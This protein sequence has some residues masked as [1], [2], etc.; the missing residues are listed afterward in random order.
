[1]AFFGHHEVLA[2]P[3]TPVH[4]GIEDDLNG[5]GIGTDFS[6][7]NAGSEEIGSNAELGGS[8]AESSTYDLYGLPINDTTED[9]IVGTNTVNLTGMS[10]SPMTPVGTNGA[11]VNGSG[12]AGQQIQTRNR[13]ESWI[14]QIYESVAHGITRQGTSVTTAS[15]APATQ[16][17]ISS[18][19]VT[20]VQSSAAGI[21]FHGNLV[22][23]AILGI[24]IGLVVFGDF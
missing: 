23:F 5:G 9:S 2:A 17:V 6:D 11:N 1:M 4:Y 19:P 24:V 8:E 16:G 3:A 10:E 15:Q 18:A 13:A 21:S 20:L 22:L 7:P 12:S 14:S